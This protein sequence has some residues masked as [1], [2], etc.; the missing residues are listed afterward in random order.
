MVAGLVWLLGELLGWGRSTNSWPGLWNVGRV[1][2]RRVSDDGIS[3]L[4]FKTLW[5]LI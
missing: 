5:I 4:N 3:K 1:A 2:G